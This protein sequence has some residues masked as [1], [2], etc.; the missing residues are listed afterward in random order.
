MEAIIVDSRTRD[1]IG[2]TGMTHDWSISSE[3]RKNLRKPLI[4]AGGLK[5]ENLGEAIL[6]VRPF[7][8]DVNSGVEDREGRKD[9]EKVRDF[10]R[11]AMGHQEP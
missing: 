4:L 9:M 2:G 8:V 1:R 11:I 7:G 6:K 3:I 5:P 10:V